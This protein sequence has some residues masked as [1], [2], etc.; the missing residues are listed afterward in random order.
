MFLKYFLAKIRY[1]PEISIPNL[2][3][4]PMIKSGSL[5]APSPLSPMLSKPLSTSMSKLQTSKNSFNV[6]T[7]SKILQHSESL[8]TDL[9]T[10]SL[11]QF[12]KQR[13]S[14]KHNRSKG[15]TSSSKEEPVNLQSSNS[16]NSMYFFVFK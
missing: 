13:V 5:L 9:Q 12:H 3:S 6:T 15:V 8:R 7:P 16:L 10:M 2:I 11:E 14:R 1:P 4:S